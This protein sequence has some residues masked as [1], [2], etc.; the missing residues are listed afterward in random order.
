MLCIPVAV[1][2]MQNISVRRGTVLGCRK[3]S[4]ELWPGSSGLHVCRYLN[5]QMRV[6]FGKSLNRKYLACTVQCR[7]LRVS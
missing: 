6:I 1:P 2:V 5:R 3:K 4:V 7:G